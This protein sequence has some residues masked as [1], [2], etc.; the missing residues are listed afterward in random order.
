M[1]SRRSIASSNAGITARLRDNSSTVEAFSVRSS[2]NP[3]TARRTF[4]KSRIADIDPPTGELTG[5]GVTEN[6]DGGAEGNAACCVALAEGNGA[7]VGIVGATGIG[8]A[9]GAA[10]YAGSVEVVPDCVTE[11]RD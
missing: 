10:R 8:R 4:S 11:V 7:T 9:D 3:S 1:S 2:A 6:G 5:G